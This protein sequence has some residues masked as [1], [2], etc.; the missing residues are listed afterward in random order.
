M[1]VIN[2]DGC[3]IHVEVEGPGR[4]AGAACCR[5][6][7]APRCIC[8][9]GRS[10]PSRSTF[11]SCATTGAAT[12]SPACPKAPTPWNVSAATCWPCSMGSAS[13]RSIGADSRWAA[14]SGQWLGANAPERIERLVITNTSSYFADKNAGTTASSWCARKASR[15]LPGRTWS[16]GSPRAF[17]SARRRPSRPCATC[18]PRRRSKAISAA[19]RRCATWTTATLLPKI[20]APTLVIAGKHDPATPLEANEYHQEPHPGRQARGA[21]RRAYV[22]YRAAGGLYQGRARLL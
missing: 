3:P 4:R 14:W 9:I 10:L 1:P 22:Q 11:A 17:S 20:K 5:I 8:G 7:S 12:G 18:S 15:P 13:R 16:A 6:R 2:A 19:A 21:R